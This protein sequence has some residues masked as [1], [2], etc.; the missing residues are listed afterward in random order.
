MAF[1]WTKNRIETALKIAGASATACAVALV[2]PVAAD[3]MADQH[4][5]AVWQDMAARSLS[6]NTQAVYYSDSPIL[7]SAALSL[8]TGSENALFDSESVLDGLQTFD[9]G[10][11]STAQLSVR[12]R[13][14][15]AEAI[16]YEARSESVY[17]QMAVAEVI[18]NR[19]RHRAYPDTLC[20]V[21]YQG[22]YRV[23]GCQFS[24]TCDGSKNRTPRGRS[25]RQ[26][27]DVAAHV[28][29][30][31]STPVTNRATHYHT[32]EVDPYWNDSLLQTRAIGDHVFY[33]MPNRQERGLLADREA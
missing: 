7:Q 14:C 20:E 30:G 4:D 19:V 13:N 17:G 5:Q 33:R 6:E 32:V 11:L 10:H 18:M 27:Q 26:A 22:S 9:A 2:L 31:F 21:V 16:Y 24:F 28:M 12:E 23:T 15:L 8:D 29:M 1:T 3:R 25:W